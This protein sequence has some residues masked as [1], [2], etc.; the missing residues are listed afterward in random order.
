MTK[1]LTGEQRELLR[2]A[3]LL[4]L[5]AARPLGMRKNFIYI[6]CKQ[7]AGFPALEE[8]EH[9]KQIR[10]LVAHGMVELDQR[11]MGRST[12]IYR[13]TEKGV[14]WLDGEGLI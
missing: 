12:E 4:Q 7:A 10:Y 8:G 5:N 1:V 2:N 11:E 6:G 14:D 13:I 9:D 3:I